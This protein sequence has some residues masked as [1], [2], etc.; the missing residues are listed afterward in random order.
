M[1]ACY[2]FGCIY[3]SDTKRLFRRPDKTPEFNSI[4]SHE[5]YS[6]SVT[7]D[8]VR[9]VKVW[10][11]SMVIVTGFILRVGMDVISFRLKEEL[12]KRKVSQ[13]LTE[14]RE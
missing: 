7:I 6:P 11:G 13:K 5:R 10:F 3:Y 9:A 4:L 8:P 12:T 14:G 2:L 1:R